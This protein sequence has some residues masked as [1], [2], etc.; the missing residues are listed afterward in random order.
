MGAVI[1]AHWMYSMVNMQQLRQSTAELGCAG[2]AERWF[3]RERNHGSGQ[4]AELGRT[5]MQDAAQVR[6]GGRYSVVAAQI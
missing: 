4:V 1:S 6:L 3:R 2:A 5:W